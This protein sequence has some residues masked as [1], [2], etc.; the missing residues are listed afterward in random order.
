[1]PLAMD[2]LGQARHDLL[3][4]AAREVQAGTEGRQAPASSSVLMMSAKRMPKQSPPVACSATIH[5]A[6]MYSAV[7][8]LINPWKMTTP[9]LPH[10]ARVAPS[11]SPPH[12]HPL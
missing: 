6:G 12:P 4:D 9:F 2:E 10:P 7:P 5:P 8:S 1:M 3:G 11:A